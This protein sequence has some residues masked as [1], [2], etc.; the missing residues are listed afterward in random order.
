MIKPQKDRCQQTKSS[1]GEQ[2]GVAETGKQIHPLADFARGAQYFTLT[3]KIIR[4]R[5]TEKFDKLLKMCSNQ[6]CL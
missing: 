4:H 1:R 3:Q 6:Y 2:K 5:K